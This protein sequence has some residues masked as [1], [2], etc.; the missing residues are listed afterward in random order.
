MGKLGTRWKRDMHVDQESAK[1][2]GEQ[3]LTGNLRYLEDRA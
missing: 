1:Q 2:A 3:W